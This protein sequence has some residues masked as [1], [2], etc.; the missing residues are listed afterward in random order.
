M[1]KEK[2]RRTYRAWVKCRF[3]FYSSVDFKFV[4]FWEYIADLLQF[5]MP[6]SIIY[7]IFRSKYIRQ[8]P[9]KITSFRPNFMRY[10]KLCT[11]ICKSGSLLNMWQSSIKVWSVT[12]EGS[13]RKKN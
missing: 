3:Y 2:E 13:W 8:K 10:P 11:C 5:Q 1:G 7:I 4:K 6:F 9:H 12:S